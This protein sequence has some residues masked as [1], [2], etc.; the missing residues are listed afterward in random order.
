LVHPAGIPDQRPRQISGHAFSNVLAQT[1]AIRL[2]PQY[3]QTYG[4]GCSN[5]AGRAPKLLVAGCRVRSRRS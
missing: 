4:A 3:V 2:D 1:R 5:A